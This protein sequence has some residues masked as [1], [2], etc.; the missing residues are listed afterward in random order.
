MKSY[1]NFS[2]DDNGGLSRQGELIP[3]RFLERKRIEADVSVIISHYGPVNTLRT[4]IRSVLAQNTD[5][6]SIELVIVDDGTPGDEF[7]R[8]TDEFVGLPN[9]TRAALQNNSKATTSR[10]LAIWLSQGDFIVPLD[11]DDEIVGANA[12]ASLVRHFHERTNAVFAS[13]NM[14][15]NIIG[16][17]TDTDD[18]SWVRRLTSIEGAKIDERFRDR[19]FHVREAQDYSLWELLEYDYNIGLRLFPKLALEQLGGLDEELG[20]QCWYSAIL[21]LRLMGEFVPVRE[22]S[23]LYNIHGGNVS[24]QQTDERLSVVR[25]FLLRFFRQHGISYDDLRENCSEV[26]W[27]VRGIQES[28]F[29]L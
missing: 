4:A 20:T 2:L 26:F 27:A 8:T 12:I 6:V 24:T 15:G 22:N 14:L 23:Y 21:G 25:E 3:V 9:V 11:S 7:Q 1:L 29:N 16:D 19:T 17:I 13:S 28:D 18:I 5:Q 10:N